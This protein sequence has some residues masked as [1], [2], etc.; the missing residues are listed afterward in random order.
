MPGP[1]A[2][3]RRFEMGITRVEF[4]RLLP[5]AVGP[6]P[7]AAADGGFET[8]A[9]AIDG[10]AWRIGIAVQPPRRIALLAVPVLYVLLDVRAPDPEAARAFLDRFLLTYQ[11]AG[12]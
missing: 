5:L 2:L 9:G 3:E 1:S 8:Y 6:L 7:A 12:G 4:L 11:R 10:L